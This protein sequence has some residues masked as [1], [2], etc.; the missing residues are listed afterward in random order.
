M[1]RFDPGMDGSIDDHLTANTAAN[2]GHLGLE[3]ASAMNRT[4]IV[5]RWLSS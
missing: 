4:G 1:L 2:C 5:R 3:P